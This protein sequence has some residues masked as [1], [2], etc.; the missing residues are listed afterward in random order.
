MKCDVNKSS[1]VMVHITS[2]FL[3]LVEQEL[4]VEELLT[5][6]GNQRKRLFSF[7]SIFPGFPLCLS[8]PQMSYQKLL[9]LSACLVVNK[10][11][12][13]LICKSLDVRSKK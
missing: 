4:S 6:M 12:G 11:C 7:E 9:V 8:V 5:D 2:V 3:F 1:F 10:S 13:H